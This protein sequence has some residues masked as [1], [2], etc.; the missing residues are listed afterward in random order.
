MFWA[1]VSVLTPQTDAVPSKTRF[2]IIYSANFFA[3][4]PLI[5]VAR[6]PQGYL[7]RQQPLSQ[8]YHELLNPTTSAR[9]IVANRGICLSY[10][11]VFRPFCCSILWL[12]CRHSP[13]NRK[14]IFFIIHS[15]QAGILGNSL[16]LICDLWS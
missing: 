5:L 7:S 4:N 2:R 10:H 15:G 8:W 11:Q 3:N 6:S 12:Q 13:Q 16:A 1:R 9:C 14:N